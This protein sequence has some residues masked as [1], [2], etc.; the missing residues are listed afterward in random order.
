M[1][2]TKIQSGEILITGMTCAACSTRIEKMLE[3]TPGVQEATV[4]LV[5]EKAA[6][7]F[8]P[9]IT[10][11]QDLAELIRD[12]GYGAS[13]ADEVGAGNQ[14]EVL[15]QERAG[16]R[17]TFI[18]SALLSAPLLMAMF[19][20]WFQLESLMFLHDPWLQLALATPVQ[21]IIGFRF[22]KK[23]FLTLLHGGAGMDLLV[24]LGT[25]AA[26][27][28]SIYTAFFLPGEGSPELYFEASAIII[29]LVLMGKYLEARAKD[30]TTSAIKALMDL[31]PKS[32]RL[33]I[34]GQETMIPLDELQIG[35]EIL[36]KP[37]ES[38]PTDAEVIQGYS[39]V[40][41]S[42]ITGESLPL[43]KALGDT[44]IGGT[45]NQYGALTLRTVKVGA[46]T[47]LSQ[48]I[49]V[50]EDA[51]GNK[52]PIQSLAD[53]I[54]GIFVPVVLAVSLATLVITG[55]LTGDWREALLHSVAVLVIA[56]PCALGLATPTAIMVGTGQGARQGILV[57]G[58]EA[59]QAAGT[60]DTVVLDKTGTITRGEPQLIQFG[61]VGKGSSASLEEAVYAL[62]RFSEHPLAEAICRGLE[63]GSPRVL[64][65][66]GFE[67]VPGKGV[68]G[69][70]GTSRWRVGT[71]AWLKS[72][73]VIFPDN[74][75][76]PWL[77]PGHTPVYAS[78]A[79]ELR[80]VFALADALREEAY[81]VISELKKMGLDIWMITGDKD[82]TARHIATKVGIRNVL[83]QVLPQ[84][85]A[86]KV[87]ELQQEGKTVAMVG[88]GINDSPA[89]VQAD[90]GLAM[91]TGTDVAIESADIA[92]LGGDLQGIQK[93]VYLSRRTLAK[94]KQNLFWAFVYNVIGIPIAA[95]GLL[96]PV[97][98]GLAMSLSSVSVV[99]SSLL[100]GSGLNKK[101]SGRRKLMKTEI[102]VSGMS[103]K[104]CKMAVEKSAQ[105]VPGV[106][107]AEV[108]LEKGILSLEAEKGSIPAVKKA[109]VNAGYAVGE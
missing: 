18:I 37:G 108:N 13:L 1:Q 84:E 40:D 7:T 29:T 64:S 15:S 27:F 80:G 10:K 101:L 104:H 30:K 83:S 87:K 77:E 78:E 94:I 56:C 39:S 69:L 107:E 48:I 25:S 75:E 61:V 66:T 95:L 20:M 57:K 53:R 86:Q 16:L 99:T 81:P 44:V 88:D 33:I 32:A 68:Q 106:K 52:A 97:F 93:A 9:L 91:G 90:V 67:A 4:N 71:E 102:K 31:R 50:V 21:F 85:K 105:G 24:V 23:A 72:Q 73:G 17:I 70:I 103:C 100:L 79:Q 42:M 63:A 74:L 19:V 11:S 65:V 45:V 12:M 2:D 22:Y 92:L 47:L 14:R 82:T 60:V 109:V 96:T 41:E 58:G 51:Q 26:Y 55:L 62:E 76:I 35:Q 8:D 3:K 98:A 46:E 5:G 54:S 34:D 49:K 43:E 89:L 38:I 59:L 36:V 28:F 6:F